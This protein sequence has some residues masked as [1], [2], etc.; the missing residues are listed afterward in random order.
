MNWK[1]FLMASL[2]VFVAIQLMGYIVDITFLNRDYESLN[3]LW[4]S[5]ATS[6]IWV[7]YVIGLLVSL[8]LTYIFIK[9]RE[10]KGIPEGVRYG[11]T[12][13]LFA[14]APIYHTLWVFLPIPY[15]L[16]S[17]NLQAG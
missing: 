7:A 4:R 6:K 9:G 5:D 11:I 14:I 3:S 8:L 2:A 15:A 12:I 16:I 17:G 10:G 13:W 1:R